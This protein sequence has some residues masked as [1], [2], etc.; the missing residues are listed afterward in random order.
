MSYCMKEFAPTLGREQVPSKVSCY[1][2]YSSLS[3]LSGQG[4]VYMFVNSNQ[5]VSSEG[6]GWS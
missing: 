1:N 6:R 2:Y 4:S 3:C 5:A